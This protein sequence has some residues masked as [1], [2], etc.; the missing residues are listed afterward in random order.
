MPAASP[1]I[2]AKHCP[3]AGWRVPNPLTGDADPGASTLVATPP[4][5]RGPSA[6]LA[7]EIPAPASSSKEELHPG[8]CS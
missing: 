1:R 7:M 2:P 4:P 8:F 5:R 6:E 3:G